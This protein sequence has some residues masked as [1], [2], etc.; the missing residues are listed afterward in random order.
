MANPVQVFVAK[1]PTW[2]ALF[3]QDFDCD[4]ESA[5]AV[6]GNFGHE[7]LGFTKMQEIKPLVPGSKGGYGWPMWTGPRRTAYFNYCNRNGYKP[8]EDLPNYKYVYVELKF[9]WEKKAIPALKAAKGLYNKVVAFEREYERAHPDHKGYPSRMKW[10]QIA[11][12]AFRAQEKPEP[13]AGLGEEPSEHDLDTTIKQ[14]RTLLAQPHVK[15]VVVEFSRKSEYGTVTETKEA[16]MAKEVVTAEV[17]SDW[18]SKIN[19]VQ[20]GTF[21]VQALAM[22]SINVPPELIPILAV[23]IQG[24]GNAATIIIRTWFTTELTKGSVG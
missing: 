21:L 13:P 1:A 24:I 9:T 6:F 4:D 15:S 18:A 11:L 8:N 10:A 12:D 23:V 20:V 17:K 16:E 14:V 7:T 3:M 5:A 19:W 22:F 2:M